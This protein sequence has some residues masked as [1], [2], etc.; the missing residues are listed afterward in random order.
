LSIKVRLKIYNIMG[1]KRKREELKKE[2]EDL[3]DIEEAIE[4]RVNI[5]DEEM[6]IESEGSGEDLLENVE[7]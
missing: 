6:S 4:E 2:K 3:E 7:K 5:E 1:P